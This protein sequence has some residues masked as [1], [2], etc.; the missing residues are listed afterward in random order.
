MAFFAASPSGIGQ[1]P[2]LQEIGPEKAFMR[3]F[4]FVRLPKYG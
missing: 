3:T 1:M 2:V 4:Y